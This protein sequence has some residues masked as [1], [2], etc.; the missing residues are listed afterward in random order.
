K[1]VG[2]A[3]KFTGDGT[4][5]RVN[6]ETGNL[7]EEEI[8]VELPT[9]QMEIP[10]QLNIGAAYDFNLAEDH[11]ITL[12]GNF[13]SNS[14]SL[15]QFQGGVEYSFM[16]MFMVR[17]GVDYQKNIFDEMNTRVAANGPTAGATV[18]VP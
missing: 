13:A 9:Q 3:M 14:Y 4:Q 17:G 7:A 6:I 8:T 5:R 2:P 11:R 12:A 15:D 1:N 16:N 18:Q 10:S